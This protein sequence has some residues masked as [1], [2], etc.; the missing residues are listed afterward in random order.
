ME[1]PPE[2]GGILMAT[3][4]A[5]IMNRKIAY[6]MSRFPHLPETFILREIDGLERLGFKLS[7]YP[8]ILQSSPIAHQEVKPWIKRARNTHFLSFASIKAALDL[9][10]SKPNFLPDLMREIFREY[11]HNLKSLPKAI[12][13][14]PQSIWAAN[15]MSEEKIE[16]I[17]AH[18]ATFPALAA[19]IIHRLT[20]IP[21]SVTVHA[22]DIFVEQTMLALKLREAAFVVAIS[23]FNRA[24]LGRHLG[25]WIL[26]KTKVIHCG[27]EPHLYQGREETQSCQLTPLHIV[28]TGS[29][30]PYK[31]QI[32]LIRACAILKQRNIPFHCVIIGGGR[33]M[34]ALKKEIHRHKLEKEVQLLGPKPQNEVASLLRKGTCYVQPSVIT[35]SGKMEGI[36]VSLMEAMA[37]GLPVIASRL[38]GIP[39][40]VRPGETGFLVPPED[41]V[42]LADGLA[43]IFHHPAVAKRTAENGRRFVASTFDLKANVRSLGNH[44]EAMIDQGHATRLEPSGA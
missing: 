9:S 28:T 39:E 38:S 19:W 2:A 24:Y 30:Q 22:H 6:I 12:A 3:Q 41:P 34:H 43:F 10:C 1:S 5:P 8:L 14:V 25:E 17:H 21:F 29:L 44:F 11:R 27:I 16:H 31:G 23:Q 7:L 32:H 26:D 15:K 33:L 20:G 40:L 36:P 35:A 42:A 13:L 18:Y 37:A 4:E